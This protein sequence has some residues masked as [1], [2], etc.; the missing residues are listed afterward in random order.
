MDGRAFSKAY[1]LI[2]SVADYHH[3]RKLSEAILFD[4]RDLSALLLAPERCGYDPEKVQ[5]LLNGAATREAILAALDRMREVAEPSDTVCIYFSG[6]GWR[7]KE[8]DESFLLPVDASRGALDATAI[9]APV[10]SERLGAI[11][12]GRLLVLLDACHAGGAGTIKDGFDVAPEER[13][14]SAESIDLLSEGSGRAIM[15]S[16]RVDETSLVLPA[17]RNSAFTTAL[18]EGMGGAADFHGVGSIKLFSLYEYI[19]ERVPELTND[20]Q[21]PQ[22]QTKLEKNFAIALGPSRQPDM[23]VDVVTATRWRNRLQ[24]I[25]STL[26]PTGPTDR[27]VW[28]RAGGDLSEL[29]LG[30]YGR[31]MWFEALKLL[32]NG[33]GG[34]VNVHTLVAEALK[35]FPRNVHLLALS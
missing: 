4:A 16:S 29:T 30:K 32:A 24:T 11:K 35:D 27:D 3:A 6:H 20:R 33:G 21:H 34:D 8:S 25:L 19:A 2:I 10:L 28:E 7:S 13:N 5:L 9:S 15:C 12:A 14:I 26:Y 1:A 17:A 23:H 31:S 22:L 18:L